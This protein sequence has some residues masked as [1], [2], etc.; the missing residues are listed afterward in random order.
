MNFSPKII[1]LVCSLFLKYFIFIFKYIFS[2]DAREIYV[3]GGAYEA[4]IYA[5]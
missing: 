5:L 3:R 1:S 2:V 4:P